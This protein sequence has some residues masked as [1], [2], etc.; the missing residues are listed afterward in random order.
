MKK[1]RRVPT[2]H[3]EKTHAARGLCKACYYAAYQ[4][5]NL[6][7]KRDN[8]RA[9]RA[10]GP[11]NAEQ[12][13]ANHKAWRERNREKLRAI[14]AANYA[15]NPE[16]ARIATVRWQKANP[17]KMR[18]TQLRKYGL[19]A[20]TYDACLKTQRGVCAG[21][22]KT[23]TRN[24]NLAVDHDHTTGK[25]RGLLCSRCNSILGYASDD[26][27]TLQRLSTYLIRHAT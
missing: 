5:E 27:E 19:T 21:C 12:I 6:E 2:C 1:E 18:A 26:A 10:R 16:G 22:L 13:K 17:E 24:K 15:K 25:F 4:A 8:M 9:W 14:S 11:K 23:C 7:R 20:E 3:P